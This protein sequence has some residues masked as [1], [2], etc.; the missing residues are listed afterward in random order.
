MTLTRKHEKIATAGDTTVYAAP[1]V[2]GPA[3][4]PGAR[5]RPEIAPTPAGG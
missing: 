4:A 2:P 1:F 5:P 3:E